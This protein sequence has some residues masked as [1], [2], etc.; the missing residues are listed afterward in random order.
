MRVGIAEHT[1]E[2]WKPINAKGECY[3]WR[4]DCRNWPSLLGNWFQRQYYQY[5]SSLNLWGRKI[6]RYFSSY[7]YEFV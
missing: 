4:H 2:N 6:R 5:D 7:W 1:A 3:P